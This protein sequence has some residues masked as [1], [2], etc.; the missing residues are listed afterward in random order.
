MRPS[1][2][3]GRGEFQHEEA[4]EE[5]GCESEKE[6][7]IEHRVRSVMMQLICSHADK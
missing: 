1:S 2:A 4:Q 3:S 7:I 5:N 6:E